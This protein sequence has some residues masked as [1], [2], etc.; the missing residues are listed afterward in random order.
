M[1]IQPSTGEILETNSPVGLG[2]FL[3]RMAK[4]WGM[5]LIDIP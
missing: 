4:G 3:P 2:A 5:G 1:K